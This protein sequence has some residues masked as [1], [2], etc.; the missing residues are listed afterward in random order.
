MGVESIVT[1]QGILAVRE[2][3]IL[4]AYETRAK[5]GMNLTR[6]FTATI[7]GFNDTYG[8]KCRTW[9]D[10]AAVIKLT[11]EASVEGYPVTR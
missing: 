6:A 11:R 9:A 2:A 4:R 7:S 5:T 10:V 3:V 1:G 8:Q